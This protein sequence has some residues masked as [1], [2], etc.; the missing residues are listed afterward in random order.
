MTSAF[1]L[2]SRSAVKINLFETTSNLCGWMKS[3][4]FDGFY[5]ESAARTLRPKG[6]TG[7]TTLELIQ[8]LEL[9]N[10]IVPVKSDI[11]GKFRL[12]WSRSKSI[13]PV[14][15]DSDN[16]LKALFSSEDATDNESIF[17]FTARKFSKELA[18]LVISPMVAGICAGDAKDISSKFLVKGSR[19]ETFEQN[20]LYKKAQKE[21]WNFY[22]LQGGIQN[23]PNT[24]AE[25][26]STMNTVQINV[27]S[28]CEKIH[29]ADDGTV[30]V[31]INGKVHTTNFVISSLPSFSL[32][33]LL[34]HQ[35]P[36]LAKDL[37]DMK[38]ID[39]ATINLHFQSEDLLKHKGFGV[40]VPASENSS[41]RGIIF[42]SCCFDMKGTVLTVMIGGSLENISEEK[43]LETSLQ[44][45]KEILG[46]TESP[47]KSTVQILQKS[48]PQYSMGHYERVTRIKNY[49]KNK[50]LPLSVC[51]QSFDGIGVN[52]VILSAKLAAQVVNIQ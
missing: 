20:E 48:F 26:L 17:D 38:A 30:D 36:E 39:V 24:I 34:Q 41:V 44:S 42:D 9:E 47:D 14:T 50:N 31:T 3:Q 29:F 4:Q 13:T 7:N 11:R 18:E 28:T 37:S 16:Q 51:G 5:F 52:E 1:Y 19:S 15:V 8:M 40:F 22:S 25:K 6:N 46:I 23:L 49:I 12:V 32:S 33:P 10:K 21:R 35:H 27:D 43:L 45:V 2:G